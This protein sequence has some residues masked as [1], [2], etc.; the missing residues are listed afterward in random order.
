MSILSDAI[1]VSRAL[2]EEWCEGQFG[3]YE[4]QQYH[5]NYCC[6]RSPFSGVWRDPKKIKHDLDCPVLVAIDLLTGDNS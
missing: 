4:D 1:I 2:L 5:C 6:G 3:D